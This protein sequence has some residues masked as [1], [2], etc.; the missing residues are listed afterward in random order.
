[1]ST[2]E[3]S[4]LQKSL[5]IHN[6]FRSRARFDRNE[7]SGAFGDIGTDFPL[8][9]GMILASGL[10]I[11]SVL[12][13][14]GAMQILTG[15][16]YGMPM[17][18]QPLKAMAVIVIAQKLSGNTL[19]GA[20]LAI[21]IVM[22]LLTITGSIDWL[23]RAVPKVVVRGIQ[24]GLGLQLSYLALKNY[25]PADGTWGY[26]LAGAAF[27]LT[28]LLLGNRRFPPALFVIAL[29][30][31]YGVIFKFGGTAVP[32]H[33][34]GIQ[35]PQFHVPVWHDIYFG[36]ILLAIPQ[37]PLSLGNSILATRQVADDLFPERHV[38]VKK[39]SA[40][41]SFMN[42]VNPFFS[43]IPVCHGSGGI[44][45]HY[46]F[47]GRTGGSVIIYG[48]L[49]LIAGFFFS[50]GFGNMVNLFPLPVLGIILLFE[51][52]A[53]MRLVRDTMSVPGD[54]AIVLLVGLICFGVPYGY[55]VGLV[56]GTALA[57]LLPDRLSGMSPK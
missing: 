21:G 12:I 43:G 47:G 55:V 23:G 15:L 29:G 24:F 20:G 13:C 33:G 56:I 30:I 9:V 27:L 16:L 11:P 35:L 42:L 45:G 18:A 19:Y 17:P 39:I 54:F 5:G 37:I 32:N 14:F 48:M 4:P 3:A 26:A 44:A 28:I 1:V 40:T 38:T 8:I 51:S 50:A 52:L 7:F 46:A 25:I 10:H 49:Y 34:F 53:Q 6:W 2:P 36:F 31:I 57:Y 41:Y 22:L